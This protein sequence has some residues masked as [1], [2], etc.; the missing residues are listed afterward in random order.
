M[1]RAR[2]SV[3]TLRR[4]VCYYQHM[5]KTRRHVLHK[6]S[7]GESRA[8]SVVE[9]LNRTQCQ[10]AKKRVL[11]LIQLF[12]DVDRAMVADLPRVGLVS[13]G[14]TRP[15]KEQSSN[16]KTLVLLRRKLNTLLQAFRVWAQPYRTSSGRWTL[17][18]KHSAKAGGVPVIASPE[19]DSWLVREGDV[20]LALLRLSEEGF[21]D[22]VRKCQFCSKW[23]FARFSHQQYCS[24]QCQLKSYKSSESWKKHRREW[25][26]DYRKLKASGKVR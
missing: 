15:T 20:V 23:L 2:S 8:Y 26:R 25:T 1:P 19:G 4:N 21:L 9:W 5:I 22:R 18:W 10:A 24:S 12:R 7:V 11:H 13:R 17:S 6:L 16:L 3:L 14:K